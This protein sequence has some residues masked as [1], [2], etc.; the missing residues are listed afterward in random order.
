MRT[1]YGIVGGLGL[2]LAA[3]WPAQTWAQD[4]SKDPPNPKPDG[5]A[6]LDPV[7][8]FRILDA[9]GDGRVS[10]EE[11]DEFFRLADTNRDNSVSDQELRQV[12]RSGGAR[13]NQFQ[14]FPAAQP[15]PGD[16]APDFE[17]RDLKGQTVRLS[18]LLKTKPVVIEFGSFT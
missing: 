13:T 9:N 16:L 6:R 15:A 2:L 7:A 1:S 14:R 10:K 17:L 4:P 3:A 5:Q 11:M 8:L 12:L 18:D